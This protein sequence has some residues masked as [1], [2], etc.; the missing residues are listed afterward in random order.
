M[1]NIKSTPVLKVAIAYEGA[2]AAM[3]ARQISER[4]AADLRSECEAWRLE[5]LVH[6]PLRELAV[7]AASEADMI[8]IATRAGEALPVHVKDWIESWLPR[9]KGGPAALV[10]LFE[11]GGETLRDSSPLCAYLSRIAERGGMDFFSKRG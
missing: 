7:I 10:A 8:I 11:E 5:S 9:R 1:V 6:P 2:A 4:L 3:C